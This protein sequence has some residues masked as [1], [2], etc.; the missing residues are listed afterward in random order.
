LLL[1]L[2]SLFGPE[3]VAEAM[4]PQL[5][6]DELF[7][8][9]LEYIQSAAPVRRAEF[10][11]ARVCARRALAA[12]GVPPMS[13]APQADRSP[14]W[15]QGVTGSIS[16]TRDW[17]A[18]VVARHP[19]VRALGLDLEVVRP[20]DRGVDEMV[21]TRSEIAFVRKGPQ[22]L[23][24]EL[25]ILFFSAKEAYYKCQYPLTG[26]FLGFHDVEIEMAREGDRFEARTRTPGISAPPLGG[27]FA[28]AGGL[29]MC[30]VAAT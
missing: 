12:L 23:Q 13:L 11:T 26:T 30:G 5:V 22:E 7:P 2:R 9:E 15:P 20:L 1:G 27:R 18:V 24:D 17:C 29:L 3:V 6:D 19:P 16:H 4:P 21:L 8:D 14:R 10:G 25:V 28:R